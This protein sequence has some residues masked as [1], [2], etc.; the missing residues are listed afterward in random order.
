MTRIT[1]FA[2]LMITLVG[3]LSSLIFLLISLFGSLVSAQGPL[4]SRLIDTVSAAPGCSDTFYGGSDCAT[5]ISP[6][7]DGKCDSQSSIDKLSS[8]LSGQIE[9]EVSFTDYIQDIVVYLL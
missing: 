6:C 2:R 4:A 9:T 7:P 5:I 8:D 1:P 3:L